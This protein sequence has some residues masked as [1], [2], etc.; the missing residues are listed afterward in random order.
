MTIDRKQEKLEEDNGEE[1]NQTETK[2]KHKY[3]SKTLPKPRGWMHQGLD[4]SRYHLIDHHA[5]K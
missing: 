3:G 5:P 1:D 2:Y 4:G